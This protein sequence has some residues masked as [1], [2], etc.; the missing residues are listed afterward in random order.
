MNPCCD[1]SK[2]LGNYFLHYLQRHVYSQRLSLKYVLLH[3]FMLAL[4]LQVLIWL[5]SRL[6][7]TPYPTCRN[8]YYHMV[9]GK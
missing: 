6:W 9:Q 4:V 1:N 3:L 8:T 2:S 7:N 5:E